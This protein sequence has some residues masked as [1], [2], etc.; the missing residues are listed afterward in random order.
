M[1]PVR[2]KSSFLMIVTDQEIEPP[3][4]WRYIIWS[5]FSNGQVV[6]VAPTDPSYW[7]ERSANRLGAIKHRVRTA[8]MCIVGVALGLTRCDNPRCFLFGQVS[9]AEVLD[10][11]VV[12]GGEHSWTLLTGWG[13]SPRPTDPSHMQQMQQV[14]FPQEAYPSSLDTESEWNIYE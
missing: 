3:A 7:R 13:Y 11:M 12:L 2:Y 8:G 10:S 9:S 5:E 1:L 14:S 6:S 4:D